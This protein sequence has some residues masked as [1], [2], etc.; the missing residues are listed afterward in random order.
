MQFEE[1]QDPTSTTPGPQ[2]PPHPDLT[3]LVG[4]GAADRGARSATDVYALVTDRITAALEGGTVPW[5]KP[6]AAVGMPRNLAS[7][8]PYRGMNVLLLSLGQ[9]YQSPWWLTFKQAQEL[10]GRV[11]KGE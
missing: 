7:G 9:P 5:H 8:R 2:A 6:W 3:P 11:Q 4:R 1:R 10:G